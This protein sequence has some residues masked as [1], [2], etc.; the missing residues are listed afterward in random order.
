MTL[1]ISLYNILIVKYAIVVVF[2]HTV[3]SRLYNILIV[4]YAIGHFS[5]NSLSIYDY[6]SFLFLII[7]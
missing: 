3:P 7:L 2:R 1:L 5:N 4:K 6:Y